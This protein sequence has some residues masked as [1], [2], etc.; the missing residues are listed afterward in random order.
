LSALSEL[1]RV[2][3]SAIALAV[4]AGRL[5]RDRLGRH[6]AIEFKG[7]IDLVTDVDKAS[8]ALIASGIAAAWP[9]HAML[10][11]EGSTTDT[12]I[13]GADWVWIVDPIDG[14]TNFAHGY[15]HFCV[16]IAI[17]RAGIG[18]IGVIYDPNRDELFVGRR[19]GAASLNGRPILVSETSTLHH[20]ILSSG[21]SYDRE[22]RH[23]QINLWAKLHDNCQG[24]RREG[25]AALGVAWMAAGRTD[26]FYEE[27]INPWDIAGGAII[28]QAAGATVTTYNG[29]PYG[30][31]DREIL[32]TNG[33]IH[34]E[35]RLAIAD[36]TGRKPV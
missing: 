15:P 12:P 28:A 36:A 7:E 30:V 1:D 32:A 6:G 23:S 13:S 31:F 19:D 29:D 10:G 35:L 26:G 20:S 16:S 33:L 4:E 5:Q 21:F 34:E 24:I 3:Q 14:T 27:P 18:E 11:E 22:R 17:A 2:Q 25:S 9:G 8:E